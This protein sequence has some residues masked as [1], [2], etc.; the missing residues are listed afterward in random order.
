MVISGYNKYD[1]WDK[2]P[3]GYGVNIHGGQV[4][5]FP[6]CAQ[7][8]HASSRFLL[9]D[10]FQ[11]RQGGAYGYE[12]RLEVAREYTDA[13]AKQDGG[14]RP[15]ISALA[16]KCQVC[17]LGLDQSRSLIGVTNMR[18]I[19][20]FIR[21]QVSWHF[22]VKVEKELKSYGRVLKDGERKRFNKLKKVSAVPEAAASAAATRHG[23]PAFEDV[24]EIVERAGQEG[25]M[26]SNADE[27][28]QVEAERTS[29]LAEST[30]TPAAASENS[31]VTEGL[32]VPMVAA[33]IPTAEVAPR[34][35]VA[36]DDSVTLQSTDAM[37]KETSP[38]HRSDEATRQEFVAPEPLQLAPPITDETAEASKKREREEDPSTFA[39]WK[40]RKRPSK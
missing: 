3:S 26:V 13:K 23:K 35:A 7:L 19:T 28:N 25:K 12:K 24:Q 36:A 39:Q 22:V 10:V 20:R 37:R 21:L 4:S 31:A 33:A 27:R 15:D 9:L 2:A 1:A 16:K 38:L 17:V 8:G 40:G 30:K 32:A 18:L 29:R 14:K 6:S 5:F 11:F 34:N